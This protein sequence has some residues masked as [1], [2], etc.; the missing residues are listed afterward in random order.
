MIEREKSGSD[1]GD[2]KGRRRGERKIHDGLVVRIMSSPG[3]LKDVAI[4]V[5][6][7][8]W[9]YHSLKIYVFFLSGGLKSATYPT[10]HQYRSSDRGPW[11][12]WGAH[13]G[14]SVHLW[15]AD[16]ARAGCFRSS[17]NYS[18]AGGAGWATK[19]KYL[20]HWHSRYCSRCCLSRQV[21]SPIPKVLDGEK[22]SIIQL[23]SLA[24]QQPFW[25]TFVASAG[26]CSPLPCKCTRWLP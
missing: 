21:L 16:C 12:V 17:R 23:Y 13:C 7:V 26:L 22:L 6:L 15:S 24:N 10:W 5:A 25:E 2:I 8:T 19:P 20:A 1:G 3:T 14:Q 4:K 9:N 11:T 18:R